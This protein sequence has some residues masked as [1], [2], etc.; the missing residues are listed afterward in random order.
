MSSRTKKVL[1]TGQPASPRE[2]LASLP[3]LSD[4][5]PATLERL[6]SRALLHRAPQGIQLFEQ[7][8]TPTFAHLI[9]VGT[10]ELLAV[11]AN[12]ETFVD[13]VHA[14]DLLLPAAVLSNQPYLV[15]ARVRESATLLLIPADAFREAVASDHGFCL[16]VLACQAAQFRRQMKAAKA[17]RLRSA[18]ERLGGYL[19][20]IAERSTATSF[21][22]PLEKR[23]IASQLGMSRETLS[24]AL[25][26][27]KQSG[28][29]VTGETLHVDDISAAR[30]AFAF[31][32]LIDGPEAIHPLS[33]Q[34]TP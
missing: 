25:P 26:A 23:L 15:R 5:A 27:L 10:V 16:G 17:I 9:I 29:R 2:A 12:A 3:W 13:L 6:S 33:L 34:R 31:D 32:P 4:A 1:T 21:R 8:E 24:R 11:R 7:A 19:L 30:R 20:S 14:G 18:E 28:L 22:L